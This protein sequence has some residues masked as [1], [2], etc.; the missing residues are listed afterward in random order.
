MIGIASSLHPKSEETESWMDGARL[1][2]GAAAHPWF[3]DVCTGFT[4]SILSMKPS[5]HRM[6]A[7]SK[8]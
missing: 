6:V 3:V 5:W 8:E 1:E 2:P 7:I 4:A